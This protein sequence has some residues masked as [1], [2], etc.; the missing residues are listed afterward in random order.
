MK[1]ERHRTAIV[2]NQLSRPVVLA[3]RDGLLHAQ[4]TFFDF[5][6]GHGQDLEYLTEM[7]I[8]ANGW[9]PVHAPDQSK[10][11]ADVVN[12]G[13]VINV[14][15]D[16]SERTAV[17]RDAL[18]L[19]KCAL[20]VSAMVG[21]RDRAVGRAEQFSDGVVTKRGTFQKYFDQSEL[22]E[23]VSS[24]T[25]KEAYPAGLGVFYVFVDSRAEDAYCALVAKEFAPTD[26]SSATGSVRLEPG[27]LVVIAEHVRGTRCLPSPRELP[28]QALALG[29]LASSDD[30]IDRLATVLTPEEAR[31]LKRERRTALLTTI[32]RAFFAPSGG[33]RMSDL[34]LSQRADVRAV[35]GSM[36]RAT[37]EAESTLRGLTRPQ[38]IERLCREWTMGKLTPSALYLHKS[39]RSALPF[40][41]ELLV[42]CAE[43]LAR[44]EA[45][46]A[47]IIK[48]DFRH[49]GVSF[50]S[51]PEFD[52]VAHPRLASA[53]RVD[54]GTTTVASRC[55][56]ESLSAP[57]LHRKEL[58]VGLGH[59]AYARWAEFTREEEDLGLL[60]R[61][62]IG[63]EASWGRFLASRGVTIEGY[64]LSVG[65]PYEFHSAASEDEPLGDDDFEVPL[66][67][68]KRKPRQRA[69]KDKVEKQP[70]WTSDKIA[71]IAEALSRLGRP[72]LPHEVKVD[73]AALKRFHRVED[74]REFFGDLY[75]AEVFEAARLERWKH[76]VVYLAGAR[77]SPSGRPKIGQLDGSAQAD[78]KCL[79]SSYRQACAEAD[80]WLL[81]IG[82]PEEITAAIVS[83][84]H[85]HQ[86]IE[87]GLYFHQSLET[88]LPVILRLLLV[89]A[90]FMAGRSM[91]EHVTVVRIANDGQNV[92]FYQYEGF[93]QAGPA[94]RVF[95][96]KVDFRKRR[97][98]PRD[99]FNP[100]RLLIHRSSM[101]DADDPRTEGLRAYEAQCSEALS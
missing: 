7:G 94:R 4:R 96:V 55:Y 17:L 29:L 53:T 35:F 99:Y 74:W 50:A 20:V 36:D 13:Y 1:V 85:G 43:E 101:L 19:A 97:V 30:W 67:S 83:W 33:L 69:T 10:C 44:S 46:D 100:P 52:S 57:I 78:I 93:D 54:F 59:P 27:D 88:R 91:P 5:G 14:I 79:F 24:T 89:C 2:R 84:P 49:V 39:L 63:T 18:S 90:E 51:Y 9:D 75:C 45:V 70:F 12:L 47:N 37:R 60:G 15:E 92:K 66:A 26:S 61:R 23:Y 76:W 11:A 32:C 73:A 82:Q 62:D 71:S 16:P 77:F 81:K 98:V 34:T 80:Q 21:F 87:K 42:D 72:P 95:S 31:Q 56:Q 3:L 28:A 6:C 8:V 64:T 40:D 65:P 38:H 25:G 22:R 41:L 58:F 86:S 68:P 48:L